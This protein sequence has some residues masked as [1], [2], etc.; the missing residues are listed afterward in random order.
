MEDRLP[1]LSIVIAS[2]NHDQFITIAIE[3]LLNQSFQDFELIIVD[4]ASGD[5]SVE[6]IKKFSDP[7]IKLISLLENKGVCNAFNIGVFSA[8]GKYVKIFASDDVAL[9]SMLET[10]VS[11]LEKNTSYDAAFSGVQVIDEEGNLLEKK[12]KKFE[13]YFSSKNRSREEWLN[14]FFTKGN[15]LAAPTAIFK[16]DLFKKIGGFDSRLAQAHDFDVWVKCCLYGQNI[17]V[18]HEKLVQYRRDSNNQNLSS[19]T[20]KMRKRLIFDNEKVLERYLSITDV[21]VLVKIFPDLNSVKEKL[22]SSLIPFFLAKQALQLSGTYYHKQFATNVIYKE[23]GNPEVV[24]KLKERFNFVV[25]KDFFEIIVEN[26]IGSLLEKLQGGF[27]YKLKR[28]LKK[29]F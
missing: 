27:C 22:D 13:R 24:S 7:R 3:S 2:Y 16:T 21:D 1:L 8:R 19:N 29:I 6:V 25:N 9:P 15:C 4:D 10:Q 14:H 12:T 23:L 5:N 28:S 11:F 20:A 26:P 17:H 18:F